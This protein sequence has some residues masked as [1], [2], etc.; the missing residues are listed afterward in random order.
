MLPC[1]AR[2]FRG[3]GPVEPRTINFVSTTRHFDGASDS[4]EAMHCGT[5]WAAISPISRNGCRFPQCVD[6]TDGGKANYTAY[7]NE[8]HQKVGFVGRLRQ[9]G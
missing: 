1:P 4:G 7:N 8:P 3:T 9:A 2:Y 5:V 6:D